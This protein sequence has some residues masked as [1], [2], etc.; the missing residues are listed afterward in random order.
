M[1]LWAEGAILFFHLLCINS[2][3]VVFGKL[4]HTH[5]KELKKYGK[6][7]RVATTAQKQH[8]QRHAPAIRSQVLM[9]S[10]GKT[11]RNALFGG[12]P[13]QAVFNRKPHI[14]FA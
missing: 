10:G 1:R 5:Y 9:D 2:H 7:S 4:A 3:S 13:G 8:G 6:V 12:G 14:L 11:S